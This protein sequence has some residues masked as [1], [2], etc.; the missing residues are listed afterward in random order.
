MLPHGRGQALRAKRKRLPT[1]TSWHLVS[2]TLESRTLLAVMEAGYEE[3]SQ[4]WV[5]TPQTDTQAVNAAQSDEDEGGNG[6][7]C[8]V[9]GTAYCVTHLDA[10]GNAYA[11]L[12]AIPDNVPVELNADESIPAQAPLADTFL[13]HSRPDATKKIYLDFNGHTTSGTAWKGGDTLVTPA[14]TI[15]GDSSFSNAELSNIQNIWARVVESFAPFDVDVTTE[16]PSVDDLRKSGSGDQRW[17][18]RVVIGKNTWGSGGAGVAYLGSFSWSS[19]TPCFVFPELLGNSNKN[20][21]M[22]TSHEVGHALGLSHDGGG[23]DGAYYGGHGSGAT[24]WAPIM[25]AGYGKSVL[26]WSKGEYSEANNHE[27]DLAIIVGAVT[28]QYTQNGNGFGYRS[29]DFGSSI[30]TAY[31]PVFSEGFVASANVAGVIER[32]DDI[33]VFKFFTSETIQATISPAAVGPSLDVLAKILDPSGQVLYQSNP[34]ESLAASFTQTVA[35]GYYYLTVEGT[36]K[37][38]VL[39]GGYSDY[40]SLGQYSFEL[41]VSGVDGP[42]VQVLDGVESVADGS[43]A[44]SFGATPLGT[45]VTKTFAVNNVGT[46][47]LVVQ[48]VS[49]TGDFLVTSNLTAGAVIPAGGSLSF[50]VQF[51]ATNL[52]S[53]S[54]TV[55]FANTDSNED[56]FD[57]TVSGTVDPPPAP[58]V[59]V[60]SGESVVLDGTG[61]V[62]FGRIPV[63]G[64]VRK[65]FTVEN[66]G[67]LDMTV[68]PISVPSGFTI[69][70]NFS[71]N[72]V[73]AAG[74]DASFILEFNSDGVGAAGG[75]VSFENSDADENPFEFTIAGEGYVPPNVQ[76]IDDGDAG[77]LTKGFWGRG[78]KAGFEG[79]HRY[80]I[81]G[82]RV[83]EAQ[84][85]AFVSPGRYRVSATWKEG[86]NRATNAAFATFDGLRP[87]DVTRMN[88]ELAPDDFSD[89]G[90]NWEDIGGIVEVFGHELRVRLSDQAD[91]YVIADAIRFERVGALPAPA[92][93]I[94]VFSGG[95]KLLDGVSEIDF[96]RVTP[97]TPVSKEFVVRNSGRADLTVQPVVVPVGYSVLQNLNAGMVL[98]P[99][100]ETTF[101]IQAD[102]VSAGLYSGTLS[103]T[104]SDADEGV[105][106]LSLQC[107]VALPAEV[108]ILDDGSEGF[109]A[110][111]GWKIGTRSGFEGDHR[112]VSNGR[113]SNE[114]TW[115]FEV[116]PG[117]YQIAATWRPGLALATDAPYTVLQESVAIGGMAS[118]AIHR[119]NQEDVPDD[120]VD[121]GVPWEV[122]GS[123]YAVEGTTLT[124]VLTDDANQ[125]V[126]ADAIRIQRLGD[127]PVPG[128]EISVVHEG[129]E[130]LDETGSVDFG[131]TSSGRPISKTFRVGNSG[132]A[133]LTVQPVTVPSGF[134]VTANLAADTVIA[135]GQYETFVVQFDAGGDGSYSGE[136]AFTSTDADESPYN[137]SISGTVA[138]PPVVQVIDD[139]DDGFVASG[140][141]GVGLRSGYD[142]GH[143]WSAAGTGA[144]EATWTF[145]V[146]PGLYRVSATWKAGLNR[147]S[148]APFTIS[149]NGSPVSTVSVNQ[150][151]APRDLFANDRGWADLGLPHVIT[152]TELTVTLTDAANQYVIA[153][154]IRIERLGDVPTPGPEIVVVHAD[155]EVADGSGAVDFGWTPTGQP[156]SKTFAVR[157]VGTADL[158]VQPISVPAGFTVTT[159]FAPDT[160]IA[161]G[162]SASFGVRLDA[163]GNGLYTGELSF[164]STDADESPFNFSVTGTVQAPPDVQILDDRD[165]GFLARGR[166]GIGLRSGYQGG[167]RWTGRGDGADEATWTFAVTPGLYRVSATWKAGLSRATNAPFTISDDGTAISTVLVN[168]EHAPKDLLANDRGW[169]DLGLPHVI[170]GTELTVTL[171]DAANEY[172]IADAIRIERL[173][174][175]PPGT[176]EVVVVY[177]GQIISDGLSSIDFGGTA[178]GAPISRV[179]TV[180]NIGRENLTVQPITAPTG[181]SVTS[182]FLADTV[183]APGQS[184][185]FEVTLD[186][187]GV[188][189]FTGDVSFLSSDTD[190]SPFAFTVTGE[191]A[192]P[193]AVQVLD[194]GAVG[195]SATGQWAAASRA[196]YQRDH[197]YSAMGVGND[198]ATWRFTVTPGTYRV[199][200]TWKAGWNRASNA[201][202]TVYDGTKPFETI[203]VNQKLTPNDLLEAEVAWKD[204]GGLYAVTGTSLVV[205]L[206]DAA[207]NYVIADAV[208]IERI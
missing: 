126:V 180:R 204:I 67:L 18:I 50:D 162:Q 119:L 191:V 75:L 94:E 104:N 93:E 20:I 165:D 156:V 160:V 98:Q 198:K 174:D 164:T 6:G 163:V 123:A 36:G 137:F 9:C 56:P 181:F 108:Q 166:W 177:E 144:D 14:Y 46:S 173:G 87:L 134:T 167:H 194:D 105:F 95:R 129:E 82:E 205:T 35:S 90:A 26:H 1:Q 68:Q 161:A 103:F 132:T 21:G 116:V 51:N 140:R 143:R 127:V 141:W 92:P 71:T 178:P 200:A 158:T 139:S 23:G 44:A 79:D 100:Q 57:F 33:D 30:E 179:F 10:D 39:G 84:W 16:E 58:E 196:G 76:I 142:G 85:T 202:F 32:F 73:I 54:G 136:L 133:D 45:P 41:T 148:N 150:E 28:T 66:I 183:I 5:V 110:T 80:N 207:D 106:D 15:D 86:V 12:S 170:T 77:F 122:I 97:G 153:D 101:V 199:S 47:E 70:N 192:V 135:P 138:P 69:K 114:A 201:P 65:V 25:G 149:D 147:A 53:Y 29:D 55:S 112:F 171:T 22:A 128:P 157:N 208:R 13:L 107:R 64:V 17:G 52:G 91:Q 34:F 78:S 195:F 172:V 60:R 115:T 159:N 89:A 151:R 81:A 62:D 37:G 42:E 7:G 190:E 49:V 120:F 8:P 185:T 102:G 189:V 11:E 124:V 188:G 40:G 131:S 121:A 88:Q 31:E 125:Y 109:S 145:A 155:G 197:H 63:G 43:G 176:P 118:A 193:P 111:D 99:G 96:G 38:D 168:Q 203:L 182:N 152:G 83:D 206:T 19:D 72:Q 74:G 187:V 130:V 4:E 3:L 175:V 61:L 186:A 154:A 27:D 184:G 24:S 169:K 2:E 113:G 146:T 48:P 59:Q 117:L